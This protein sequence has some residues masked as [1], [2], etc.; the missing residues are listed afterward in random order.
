VLHTISKVLVSPVGNLVEAIL[1]DTTLSY[2]AAAV[3]RA[4]QGNV[5]V[6]ALL[7]SGGV[8]TV[9]APTNQAFRNAGFATVNDINAADPNV[10]S[11]ILTYHVLA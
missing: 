7:S 2:L 9:F 6:A 5:N 10:L 4:S 11:S 8:F 3:V 1:A